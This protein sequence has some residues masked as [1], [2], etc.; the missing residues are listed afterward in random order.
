MSSL[1]SI[2]SDTSALR[3]AGFIRDIIRTTLA[4][5]QENEVES[6]QAKLRN[7]CLRISREVGQPTCQ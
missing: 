3:E 1:S 5:I 7:C 4:Y 2:S 6:S